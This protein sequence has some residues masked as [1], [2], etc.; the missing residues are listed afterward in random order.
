[1]QFH[2]A[3]LKSKV[4]TNSASTPRKKSLGSPSS[5]PMV[6]LLSSGHHRRKR[7][8][9][10]GSGSGPSSPMD[11]AGARCC[12]CTGDRLCGQQAHQQQPY[13]VRCRP[14]WHSQEVPLPHDRLME[15]RLPEDAACQACRNE[16][17]CPRQ[18]PSST[19]RYWKPFL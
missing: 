16:Q 2:S 18:L 8:A 12:S 14:G 6:A 4:R 9:A 7:A 10:L 19:C 3:P 1:M 13:G 5:S 17:G 15:R 11:C